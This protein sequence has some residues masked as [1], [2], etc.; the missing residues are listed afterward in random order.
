M[1]K[2]KTTYVEAK[3][4]YSKI[5]S[6]GYC[7]LQFLLKVAEPVC[8]ASGVYGWNCDFYVF[9][10]ICISTGYRPVGT[11]INFDLV[12]KYK[13]KVNKLEAKELPYKQ[14]DAIL[15]RYLKAFVKELASKK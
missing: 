7:N 12:K 3:K 10:S 15:K 8:Y 14:E 13:D 1:I 4:H 6:A 11:P 9:D 5:Y 2:F